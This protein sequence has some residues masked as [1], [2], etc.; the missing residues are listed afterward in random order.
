MNIEE[1]SSLSEIEKY[2]EKYEKKYGTK[3][4]FISNWNPSDEIVSKLKNELIINDEL[5]YINYLFSYSIEKEKVLKVISKLGFKSDD[6]GFLVTPSGS[7]SI[8]SIV[9][10]I[11]AF[12]LA[13]EI[14]T[15]CPVYFSLINDCKRNEIE[16][17]KIFLE[18]RY[19]K[20]VFPNK[21]KYFNKDI[22][23][24]TNPIYCTGIYIDNIIQ[25]LLDYMNSGKLLI[26][27]ECLSW[28]GREL[29]RE[30][31]F[32]KNFIGIYSPHKSICV[33]GIKF[34][35]IVFDKK[36]QSY[37]NQW[38][39]VINGCLSISVLKAM[40]HFISDHYDNYSFYL[41]KQ[42]HNSISFINNEVSKYNNIEID[43][44]FNS[45]LITLYVHNINPNYMNSNEFLWEVMTNTGCSFI[46][47]SRNYFSKKLGFSFRINLMLY[48]NF[49]KHSI[50]RLLKFLGNL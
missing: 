6:K 19:N 26:V 49:F 33:N 18:K 25:D 29:A 43:Q 45:Y 9:Y 35:I 44:G 39:D 50:I 24:V 20:F 10:W 11:K 21:N 1:L 15:F 14:S 30:L 3:P 37:F 2:E 12:N 28:N 42:L 47:G 22:L 16:I 32:H 41:K 8:H 27:D 38:A 13:E 40:D 36:Y 46:P 17:D 34:S 4:L 5:N 31:G 48:N 7:S 23:W